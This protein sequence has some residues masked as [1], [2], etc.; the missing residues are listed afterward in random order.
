MHNPRAARMAGVLRDAAQ[1]LGR[2][3]EV[4]ACFTFLGNEEF[5]RGNVRISGADPLGAL[6]DLGEW[7]GRKCLPHS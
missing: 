3:Q 4:S 2:V 7:T 5:W 6:G 1:P